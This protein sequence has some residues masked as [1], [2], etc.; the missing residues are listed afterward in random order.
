[1]IMVRRENEHDEDFAIKLEEL[2]EG[3]EVLNSEAHEL[4]KHIAQNV[5]K[6]L[7]NLEEK[8]DNKKNSF[9]T[10]NNHQ[11]FINSVKSAIR[12]ND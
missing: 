7:D 5:T 1:M 11:D 4:E 12:N 2:Q 9:Q 3:L 8:K 10:D 6:I